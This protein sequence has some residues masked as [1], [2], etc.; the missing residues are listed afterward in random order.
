MIL[1]ASEYLSKGKVKYLEFIF[2][3]LDSFLDFNKMLMESI[4]GYRGSL[5]LFAVGAVGAVGEI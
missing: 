1:K 4:T 2:F 5:L 3:I